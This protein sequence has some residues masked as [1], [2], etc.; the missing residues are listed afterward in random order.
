MI[1]SRRDDI[2]VCG[3][4]NAFLRRCLEDEARGELRSLAHYQAEFSDHEA[5]IARE[6][7]EIAPIDVTAP[8]VDA[9]RQK[10]AA[11]PGGDL[12]YDFVGAY[13][14]VST[15]GTGGMGAVYLAEQTEPISRRVAL[16]LIKVGESAKSVVARFEAERQLLALLDH[17]NIAR[18]LDAGTTTDGRPFFV[19]EYIDGTG[20]LDY[21]DRRCTPL[22]D[23]LRIFLQICRGVRH[24]H[25]NGIIHR[26]LK[27]SNVLVASHDGRAVAK[28]IDFGIAKATRRHL[29]ERTIYTQVGQIVGTPQ[30]M[31]PEQA[32]ASAEDADERTDVYSL[33]VL[34]YHLLVGELPLEWQSLSKESIEEVLRRIREDDPPPPSV[35]WRRLGSAMAKTIAGRYRSSAQHHQGG[36]RGDLDWITMKAIEKD[37]WR[38]YRSVLELEE[39]IGRHLESQPISARRPSAVYRVQKFV[40]R[41]RG[42]VMAAGAVFLVLVVGLV[43]TL[44]QYW[45]ASRNYED[46]LLLGDI[47]L[48][49][50]LEE[51]SDGL[52][53][54]VPERVPAF[55]SWLARAEPLADRL[56]MHRRKLEEIRRRARPYDEQA[57]RLDRQTHPRAVELRKLREKEREFA[58]QIELAGSS[59]LEAELVTLEKERRNRDRELQTLE[60]SPRAAGDG[61]RDDVSEQAASATPGTLLSY[62]EDAR[63]KPITCYFRAAFESGS[64]DADLRELGLGVRADDGVI[65]YLNGTEVYRDNLSRSAGPVHRYTLAEGGIRIA[66]RRQTRIDPALLREGRNLVAV[67]VHQS[68]R[69]SRDLLLS[70]D[71]NAGARVLIS[72]HAR[73]RYRDDEVRIAD[74][75]HGLDFDDSDWKEGSAP[76]GY[77]F[78]DGP[79]RAEERR[80]DLGR[81]DRQIAVLKEEIETGSRMSTRRAGLEGVRA[82]L[83]ETIAG[84]ESKVHGRRTWAFERD[85]D[86][87]E[88]RHR[89]K[90]VTALSSFAAPGSADPS[91]FAGSGSLGTIASIRH[92]VEYARNIQRLSVDDRRRDWERTIS[93]LADERRCPHY[94]GLRI[95]PQIG[96]VPIG[97]DPVTGLREFAH[98]P[99]GEIP[100]RDPGGKLIITEASS[101][102]LVLLPGGDF[103]MGVNGDDLTS[104]EQP[105]HDVKLAA[106]FLSKLEVTQSQ[107]AR[108]AGDDPSEYRPW[109]TFEEEQPSLLHPVESVSRGDCERALRHAGLVLPTEAQWEYAARAGTRTQWYTGDRA[110][111]LRGHANLA[112]CSWHGLPE[113]GNLRQ[114]DPWVDGHARHAPIGSFDAN[115]FGLHDVVG[116]VWEWCRGDFVRYGD[117]EPRADDGLRTAHGATGAQGVV[118]GGSWNQPST[119]GSSARRLGVSPFHRYPDVGLRPARALVVDRRRARPAGAVRGPATRESAAVMSTPVAAAAALPARRDSRGGLAGSP[120]DDR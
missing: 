54:A 93:A 86:D 92:R 39:D 64:G 117:S 52:S 78:P 94:G 49:E 100:R 31:S 106:F 113:N 41:N 114:Y 30:Y 97:A 42:P 15:L 26:D 73:W 53:P 95:S 69:S 79:L 72:R 116:N 13:R 20:L 43:S 32:S 66:E 88:H 105:A 76:L 36:L 89:A 104:N 4:L 118:R 3:A 68:D 47:Q 55:E 109:S 120:R 83:A 10:T 80:R 19:M 62:G 24:A 2:E 6:Y 67:E 45:H 12:P 11:S 85:D 77:G 16:K 34:L 35:R 7:S 60:K 98:L 65:V 1:E 102:V 48:L 18:V 59:T 81:M 119:N 110:R 82:A 108:L 75:W 90:L 44:V 74:S 23:R 40:R 115:P 21:C 56:P 71:L 33:G 63:F 8:I 87:R 14:L 57:H 112:D 58:A 70:L 101:I 51:E 46:A 25:E 50:I 9:D 91:A 84:L 27:P 107:W 5:L 99:S 37:R 111:G 17:P 22:A 96:L 103:R 29:T 38:R 61:V 28:I